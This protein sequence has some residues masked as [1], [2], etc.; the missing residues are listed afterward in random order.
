MAAPTPSR[1]RRTSSSGSMVAGRP[2]TNDPSGTIVRGVTTAPAATIVY[3]PISA[4]S[5]MVA[6]LPSRTLSWTRPQWITTPC[7]AVTL[8]PICMGSPVWTTQQSS[9][10]VLEPMRIDEKSARTTADGQTLDPSP[11][12]TS[13]IT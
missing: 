8:S 10:C 1:A 9:R 3:E 11:I 4:P 2:R 12:S 6:L 7:P 13:P 5:R